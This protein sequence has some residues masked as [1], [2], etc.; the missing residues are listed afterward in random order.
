LLPNGD[1]LS[2]IRGLS[3]LEELEKER[4]M[5]AHLEM[6]DEWYIK[7]EGGNTQT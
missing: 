4:G 3:S 1:N 6:K 5:R 7:D 2:A